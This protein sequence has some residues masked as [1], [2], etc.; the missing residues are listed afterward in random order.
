MNLTKELILVSK[1]LLAA[2]V[3]LVLPQLIAQKLSFF[4]EEGRV[5]VTH[6]QDPHIEFLSAKSESLLHQLNSLFPFIK[7]QLFTF[8]PNSFHTSALFPSPSP[9]I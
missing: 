8:L 7:S 9:L 3:S 1:S 5:L 6:Q 2:V 4:N